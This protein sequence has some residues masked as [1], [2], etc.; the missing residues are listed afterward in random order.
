LVREHRMTAGVVIMNNRGLAI[1]VDSAVTLGVAD[2]I[3][4]TADKLFALSKRHP[5]GIMMYGNTAIMGVEWEIII[6]SYRD[7]LGDKSFDSLSGYAEDFIKYVSIFPYFKEVYIQQYLEQMCINFLNFVL[8]C[9]IDEIQDEFDDKHDIKLSQIEEVLDVTLETIKTGLLESDDQKQIRLDANYIDSNLETFE[10]MM[11]VVFENYKP[12]KKQMAKMVELFKLNIQKCR[13]INIYTGVVIV[14]YGEQDIYP[15]RHDFIV[16]GK[17]GKSLIYFSE[18]IDRIGVDLDSSIKP[19]AQS[20]TVL[21]FIYGT[22]LN[23]SRSIDSRF[24]DVLH[25]MEKLLNDE[26]KPKAAALSELMSNYINSKIE[27]VY[28]EPIV[29]IVSCMH[30]TELVSMAEAMVNLTALKK[31]VSTDTES[32]GGPVDVALITKGDGF[33]WIKRKLS[34]DP[35]LNRDLNQ[36]YFR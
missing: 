5:V 36:N 25:S 13:L 7:H 30:T 1:A 33:I 9:F 8:S 10:K 6:K 15:V 4:N 16:S 28:K 24:E 2:K 35:C 31:H 3:Y 18:D 34:Y 22:D 27:N 26:D 29:S 11:G 20:E 17:I 12:S 14:G 23:F 21:Q 19:F 32:V